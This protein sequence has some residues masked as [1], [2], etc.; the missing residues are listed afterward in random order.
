[1]SRVPCQTAGAVAREALPSFGGAIG[2]GGS[3]AG[4]NFAELAATGVALTVNT[5]DPAMV[6]TTLIRELEHAES[7]HR[8]GADELIAAA[9]RFRFK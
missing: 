2:L 3:G 5:D 8:L 9:W 4:P 6:G 7:A 1:M